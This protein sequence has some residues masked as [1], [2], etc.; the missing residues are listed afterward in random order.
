M[1]ADTLSHCHEW[2]IDRPP[3]Q[4]SWLVP[5]VRVCVMCQ[6]NLLRSPRSAY[7]ESNNP[8]TAAVATKELQ[9]VNGQVLTEVSVW[10]SGKFFLVFVLD[11]MTNPLSKTSPTKNLRLN[12]FC[13]GSNQYWTQSDFKKYPGIT[14]QLGMVLYSNPDLMIIKHESRVEYS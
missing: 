13:M 6:A 9:L 1:K 11:C 3:D 12:D 10:R 2:L 4:D 7:V 8:Q 5:Y 14:W